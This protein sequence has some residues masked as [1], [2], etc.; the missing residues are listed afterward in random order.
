MQL[1]NAAIDGGHYM[2]AAREADR[3]IW[4]VMAECGINHEHVL[5]LRQV[6][7]YAHFLGGRHGRAARECLEL[8]RAW[9]LKGN[10]AQATD[11]L[12]RAAS[13]WLLMPDSEDARQLGYVLLEEWDRTPSPT[14]TTTRLMLRHRAQIGHRMSALTG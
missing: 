6:G 5:C 13:A 7:A 9:A 4:R 10:Y 11:D 3:L 1:I 14:R 12:L 2:L 8:A